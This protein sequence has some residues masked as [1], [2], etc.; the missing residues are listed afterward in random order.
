[1]AEAVPKRWTIEEFLAWDDGTDVRYG[2]VAGGIV[3]MP[4]PAEA[5][6]TIVAN[7]ASALRP[8]LVPPC[9]V[10]AR[11][12][13]VLPDRDDTYYQADLAVTC[14]PAERGRQNVAEPV[15][16]VEVL[17]PSTAVHDRGRKVDDYCR[18]PSVREIVLVGSGK[19]RVQRWRRDGERW[20]VENLIG[21]AE[22]RLDAIDAT[23]PLDRIYDGSGI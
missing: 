20:R 17:S 4:P 3:A 9:R 8:S 18:L 19:R 2:L 22:L 23:I 11:A 21:A 1:M 10:V 16:V 15:L 12:G 6:G 14:T 5:H 7:V 13:V